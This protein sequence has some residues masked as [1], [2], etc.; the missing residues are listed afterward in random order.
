MEFS[1][2]K[3]AVVALVALPLFVCLFGCCFALDELP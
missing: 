1:S 3:V 2:I